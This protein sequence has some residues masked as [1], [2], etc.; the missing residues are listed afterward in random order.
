MD[1]FPYIKT[2]GSMTLK[3]TDMTPDMTHNG[4]MTHL[5]A[6]TAVLFFLFATPLSGAEKTDALLEE[7][8]FIR[9]SS[10]E[11][12]VT[13]RLNGPHTPKVFTIK[14]EAPKIVFDFYDTTPAPSIK[15]MIKS[16]GDLVT[17]IRIGMHKDGRHKTRV[18]LDLAPAGSYDFSQD[19]D[20]Q[21][22]TLRI[23][24]FRQQKSGV[25]QQELPPQET[26]KKDDSVAAPAAPAMP[27]KA[28]VSPTPATPPATDEKGVENPPF[29]PPVSIHAI[30][31]ANNLDKGEKLSLKVE[32]FQP[33]EIVADEEGTPR[34][35]CTF[36]KATLAGNIPP[37]IPTKGRFIQL[38]HIEDDPST[39]TIRVTLELTPNRHYDLK[40]IFFK[41]ENVYVLLINSSGQGEKNKEKP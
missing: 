34:I 35:I 37:I 39:S 7:I 32:N 27:T 11:E 10:T 12:T 23:T 29:S 28:E 19:F 2:K 6:I 9:K 24:I 40:Q 30:D 16:N 38:V 13:F 33:P 20:K 36:T 4:L 15:G 8:T 26:T 3:V 17:A 18:V 21:Q 25:K 1:S 41:E 22:H 14:G 31:F 5:F